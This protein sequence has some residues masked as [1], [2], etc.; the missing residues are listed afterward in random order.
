LIYADT[1]PRA[2]SAYLDFVVARNGAI[3]IVVAIV[4]LSSF[5]DRMY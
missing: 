2:A 1:N 3:D 4:I 5:V